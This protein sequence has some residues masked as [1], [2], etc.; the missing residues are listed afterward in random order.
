M[1]Q[2]QTLDWSLQ[3]FGVIGAA[4]ALGTLS[5]K[6]GERVVESF[7]QPAPA[8]LPPVPP[9][10]LVDPLS[11]LPPGLLTANAPRVPL[12]LPA[13]GKSVL[14]VQLQYL[15]HTLYYQP[16][17]RLLLW[18][19]APGKLMALRGPEEV[20]LVAEQVPCDD[21]AT[22]WTRPLGTGPSLQTFN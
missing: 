5:V 3:N 8:V 10:Q 21:Y 14:F 9:A 7:K 2:P 11:W 15:G 17:Q 19:A 4:A 12:E 1:P 18:R 22:S 20:A 16:S 6:V 13:L